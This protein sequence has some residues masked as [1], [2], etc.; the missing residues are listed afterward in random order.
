[1]PAFAAAPSG[2]A[3]ELSGDYT[4]TTCDG[5]GNNNAWGGNGAAAFGFMPQFGGEIDG[6]Y[7]RL[8]SSGSDA[9]L[10]SI[11]GSPFFDFGQGRLGASINYD[12]LSGS[13]FH[14]HI[15][16][17]GGFGEFYFADVFT[18][19]AKG[20]GLD[21]SGAVLGAGGNGSGG[22]VSGAAMFYPIP[23]VNLTGAIDYA[24]FSGGHITSYGISG[25]WLVSETT[26]IAVYG[27]YTHHDIS[28]GF[29]ADTWHIGLKIYT[30]GNGAT[31]VDK[32]R[33]GTLGWVGNASL[34]T[35]LAF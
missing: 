26:P 17:Y 27:G 22:Y 30:Q 16:S 35:R 15:T 28:G 29:S 23:D 19:A 18:V 21:A 3:G 6:S 34:G 20:G 10:W 8:S 24:S 25:E 1:M 33:N 13:G 5:C 2:F 32:Q 7:H 31:L 4:R 11:G 9:D 14:G 12:H